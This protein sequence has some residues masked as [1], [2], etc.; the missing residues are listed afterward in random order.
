MNTDHNQTA[1]TT[2]QKRPSTAVAGSNNSSERSP[3][4]PREYSTSPTH[5]ATNNVLLIT[6][7]DVANQTGTGRTPNLRQDSTKSIIFNTSSV[8]FTEDALSLLAY[9]DQEDSSVPI[10]I[11]NNNVTPN[12]N[13]QTT[14]QSGILLKNGQGAGIQDQL[15]QNKNP[16]TTGNDDDV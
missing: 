3:V 16:D 11:A 15:I 1:T 7:E 2:G 14:Q 8:G 13:G 12:H 10:M 4:R 6:G 5:N 9:F